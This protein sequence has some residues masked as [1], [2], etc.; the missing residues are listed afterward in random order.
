MPIISILK[1][2]ALAYFFLSQMRAVIFAVGVRWLQDACQG[3]LNQFQLRFANCQNDLSWKVSAAGWLRIRTSLSALGMAAVIAGAFVLPAPALAQRQTLDLTNGKVV[4]VTVS[5]DMNKKYLSNYHEI[6]GN[7]K[8]I[9]KGGGTLD[10]SGITNKLKTGGVIRLD[11]GVVLIDKERELGTKRALLHFMGGTLRFTSSTMLLTINNRRVTLKNSGTFFVPD[12]RS[13]ARATVY[14]NSMFSGSGELKKLGFGDLSFENIQAQRFMGNIKLLEGGLLINEDADLGTAGGRLAFSGGTLRFA[15]ANPNKSIVL[16]KSRLLTIEAGNAGVFDT[17]GAAVT[18][19]VKSTLA[20]SGQ[21][22]KRGFGLLDFSQIAAASF[23]GTIRLEQGGLLIDHDNDLGDSANEL[24]FAG[25]ELHFA[26]SA[27]LGAGRLITVVAGTKNV[28]NTRGGVAVQGTLSGAGILTKKGWGALDLHNVGENDFS[29]TLKIESDNLLID[30]EDDLG[31]QQARLVLAG[32]GL[33]FGSATLT[34]VRPI[35]ITENAQLISSRDGGAIDSM[36][37]MSG[38]ADTLFITGDVVLNNTNNHI[39]DIYVN[40]YGRLV[41]NAGPAPDP[42]RPTKS[43]NVVVYGSEVIGGSFL[44]LTGGHAHGWTISVGWLSSVK[45]TGAGRLTISNFSMVSLYQD[46]RGQDTSGLFIEEGSVLAKGADISVNYFRVNDTATLEIDLAAGETIRP[47]YHVYRYVGYDYVG[48]DGTLIKKGKGML[49]LSATG[50]RIGI[51]VVEEGTV[52]VGEE[53]HYRAQF[54]QINSTLVLAGGSMSFMATVTIGSGRLLTVASSGTLDTTDKVVVV[55]STLSGSGLLNKS[56]SGKLDLRSVQAG[57]FTGVW[58]VENGELQIDEEDDLGDA[59][60]LVFAGG[61]LNIDASIAPITL[62]K[63]R[64][65]STAAGHKAFFAL[66]NTVA[67][68]TGFIKAINPAATVQIDLQEDAN[69]QIGVGSTQTLT[70]NNWI[71]QSRG[72]A[73]IGFMNGRG[74]SHDTEALLLNNMIFK[75]I[76]SS[77]LVAAKGAITVDRRIEFRNRGNF[78]D[79][80]DWS[81]TISN[82]LVRVSLAHIAPTGPST[83]TVHRGPRILS[84]SGVFA[85]KGVGYFDMSATDG[86]G[87]S[88]KLNIL[89]G[90]VKVG[91]LGTAGKIAVGSGGTMQGAGQ[92]GSVDVAVGG[93]LYHPSGASLTMVRDYTQNGGTYRVQIGPEFRAITVGGTASFNDVITMNVSEEISITAAATMTVTIMTKMTIASTLDLIVSEDAEMADW[94]TIMEAATVTG[95]LTLSEDTNNIFATRSLL[96]GTRRVGVFYMR[97]PVPLYNEYVQGRNG[98]GVAWALSQIDKSQHEAAN[99]ALLHIRSANQAR[100]ALSS[101]SGEM[102]V[103]AGSALMASGQMLEDAAVGQMRMAFGKQANSA[104]RALR[105]TAPIASFGLADQSGAAAGGLGIWLKSLE[106]DKRYGGSG[107]I[108]PLS[109]S[110]SGS[111]L[112]F[113]LPL[114]SWRGGLFSGTSQAQFAYDAGHSKGSDDSRHAGMYAARMWGKTALRTGMSYSSHDIRI[115]RK[116]HLPGTNTKLNSSYQAYTYGFFGQLDRR[117][118]LAGMQLEP[119]IGLSHVRHTTGEFIETGAVGLAIGSDEQQDIASIVSAGVGA[120]GVFRLGFARVQAQGILSW[121]HEIEGSEAVARQSLGKSGSFDV[122]GAGLE[123]DSLELDAGVDVRLNDDVR[124][125]ISYSE[126]DVL[127]AGGRDGHL[128]AVLDFSM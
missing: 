96:H 127:D 13:L 20:G 69:L 40:L 87:F 100:R 44:E 33:N 34:V 60:G 113:D 89:G 128:R 26:T 28:L 121:K 49:D 23:T 73:T 114:G 2:D 102:H 123:T 120:S 104:Q 112:G 3:L 50:N 103:S 32:G 30:S 82:R 75:S 119:F 6:I 7:G 38:S 122:Y 29:G 91:T 125:G 84:G 5:A 14:V 93:T 111:L 24:V 83:L 59:S 105:V 80:H 92:V 118:G 124:L 56:G 63:A 21:L 70:L 8:I 79:L 54:G 10:L 25:G 47:P 72:N 115:S 106:I 67:I 94:Y 52:L 35:V 22:R 57:M 31:S 109:Y 81:M 88:G 86:S 78:L 95:Q 55:K 53:D 74:G 9:K 4:R 117:F 101:L 126:L 41:A 48:G 46:A 77:S 61:T 11:E 42:M 58:R 1:L 15:A 18:V 85:K 36:I 27:V 110:S 68:T 98:S 12:S 19:V 116:L 90:T 65:I 62:S 107:D 51:F 99:Y 39:N 97:K 76:A 17:T 71:F 108:R 64:L 66:K 45:K 16:A 37:T 43:K